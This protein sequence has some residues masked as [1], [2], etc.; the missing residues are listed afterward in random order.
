MAFELADPVNNAMVERGYRAPTPG[1][2][3]TIADVL[4]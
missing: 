1:K 4:W 2:A 3:T